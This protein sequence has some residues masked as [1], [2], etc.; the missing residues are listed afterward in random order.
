MS[1]IV[2]TESLGHAYGDVVA[3]HHVSL[4][5]PEG[6]IG[7]VGAN[8]AGKTTL[9]KILLG[10]LTPTVG[11]TWVLGADPHREPTRVRARVGY[12]PEDDCLP[13]AQTAADFMIYAAEL[14]G[15]PT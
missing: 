13:R 9:I 7:L 11:S 3:L 4:E 5:I 2:A 8:G 10:I 12:M 1:T 15:I 6:R 14:A